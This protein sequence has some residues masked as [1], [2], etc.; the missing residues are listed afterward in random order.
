MRDLRLVESEMRLSR[1]RAEIRDLTGLA[2]F[3]LLVA[4]GACLTGAP[5]LGLALA[6]PSATIAAWAWF[7]ARPALDAPI[8]EAEVLREELMAARPDAS[9]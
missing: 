6:L 1:A 7:A 3:W 9:S 5:R 4:I 2:A 8:T